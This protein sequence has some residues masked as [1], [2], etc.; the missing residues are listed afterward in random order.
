[1]T[2]KT[3]LEDAKAEVAKLEAEIAA[4]PAE[5]IGKTEN[6]MVDLWHKITGYFGGNVPALPVPP[7]MEIDLKPDAVADSPATEQGESNVS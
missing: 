5:L 3:E 7:P 1:M 6:E 2:L 4:L